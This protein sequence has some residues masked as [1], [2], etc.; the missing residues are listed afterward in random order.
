MKNLLLPK[1][2]MGF[3]VLLFSSFVSAQDFVG[4]AYDIESNKLV[5]TEHHQY[6]SQTSH[7][8]IYK[9]VDGKIFAEKDI[10]YQ[11]GFTSPSIEQLNSRNGEHIKIVKKDNKLRVEYKEDAKQAVDLEELNVTPSLVVDAG[12]DHFI[13]Q[14]WNTLIQGKELVVDYLVPSSLATYQLS[15]QQYDCDNEQQYC[16]TISASNFFISMFTSQLRLSY[17]KSTRKLI[18]FQGRSNICDE[19]GDYQDVLIT[20]DYSMSKEASL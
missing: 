11:Q 13:N 18:S 9:E 1:T 16:F 2:F 8:V 7:K 5:Y 20:Y 17:D 19:N 3:I 12:F 4:Y 6:L 14:Q 10:D 15:I